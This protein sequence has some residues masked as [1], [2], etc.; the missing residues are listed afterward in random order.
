MAFVIAPD[1]QRG[2]DSQFTIPDAFKGLFQKDE[3]TTG[4]LSSSTGFEAE[5]VQWPVEKKRWI[6]LGVFSYLYA[7]IS[8]NSSML[9]AHEVSVRLL[10]GVGTKE[11][12]CALCRLFSPGC[13]TNTQ[14]VVQHDIFLLFAGIRTRHVSPALDISKTRNAQSF[15]FHSGHE[16]DRQSHEIRAWRIFGDHQL[17]SGGRR[18][19]RDRI[20]LFFNSVSN[21]RVYHCMVSIQG[22]DFRYLANHVLREHWARARVHCPWLFHEKPTRPFH[23]TVHRVYS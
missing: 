23:A 1:V 13:N 2:C 17:G 21:F 11:I 20:R 15:A 4:L 22:A 5:R 8:W 6:M 16:H 10:Y 3:S 14:A 7:L 12:R 18:D 19:L 9:V